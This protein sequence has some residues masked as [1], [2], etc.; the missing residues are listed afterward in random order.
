ML[1]RTSSPLSSI[2]AVITALS[3]VTDARALGSAAN[4]ALRAGSD[5]TGALI[6]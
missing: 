4:D 5:Q 1:K 2:A 6:F 3:P